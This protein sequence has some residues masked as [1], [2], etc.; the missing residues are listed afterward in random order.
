MENGSIGACDYCDSD[1]VAII[2]TEHIGK[3]FRSCISK[4]YEDIDAGSGAYYDSEEKDYFDSKGRIATRYSV[5][6]ILVEE[7][8]LDYPPDNNLV[9]DIFADSGPSVRD[10]QQGADDPYSDLDS[11][12]FVLTNDLFGVFDTK[13]YLI[14]EEFKFSVKH[15]NRFFD[16]DSGLS[17]R[18][19]RR[20]SL[21]SMQALLFEYV[22]I[23]KPG[24]V[25][26]RVRKKGDLDFDTLVI[27]KE[28]SPA[29]PSK[30]QIN[31]M[32]PAG[33]SYLYLASDKD[34]AC[35]ECRYENEDVIIAKY[36]SD[37]ELSILDFS[38]KV[39]IGSDSIFS[40]KYDHDT[41]WYNAFLSRFV[42]EISSPVDQ[43]NE[44]IK[45]Y[46][47]AATQVVAE[48]I[49]SLGFD[50]IGFSSSV[51]TDK[52]Y[53]FFCGPDIRYCQNEYGIFDEPMHYQLLPSFLDY[54]SIDAIELCHTT[55]DGLAERIVRV[56]D[57][58]LIDCDITEQKLND[59]SSL[60]E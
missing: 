40:D 42:E 27:N 23:V 26:Y 54:F 34:T 4:A 1:D 44:A 29:P 55:M 17:E 25:F 13:A 30:P 35:K 7:G 36:I 19:G 11:E 43:G 56:R 10:I 52:S 3:F 22:S 37:Q 45:A 32:S 53:C 41:R 47:Y 39:M 48:Y 5:K 12:Q 14:W 58:E 20:L 59:E 28:L 16:V 18:D 8:A 2:S 21:E 31:R 49:R 60:I 51:G 57:N 24:E 50:G 46:E 38:Q 6:E 9:E 15:Y 33:I